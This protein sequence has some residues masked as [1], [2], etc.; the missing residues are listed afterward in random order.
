MAKLIN[1][2]PLISQSPTAYFERL[3]SAVSFEWVT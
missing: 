2:L 3:G 1:N